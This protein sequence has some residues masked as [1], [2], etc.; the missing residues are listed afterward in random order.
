MKKTTNY[1]LNQWEKDDRI[2]M[3]DFNADN[4]KT[5]QALVDQAE[6]QKVLEAV[7]N[8]GD[9]CKIHTLTYEGA[10]PAVPRNPLSL[11]FP[12][13]PLVIL[14]TDLTAGGSSIFVRGDSGSSGASQ[15][16]DGNTFTYSCSFSNN[17]MTENGHTYQVIALM[18]DLL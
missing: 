12:K 11:T 2:Q 6:A 4:L 9:W 1:Q 14:I 16:W 8:A 13:K 10:E 17:Q 15:T 7:I 18:T 5:E 3:E